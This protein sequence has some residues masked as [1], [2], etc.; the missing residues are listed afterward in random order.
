[1]LHVKLERDVDPI[2]LYITTD[3]EVLDGKIQEM[4]ICLGA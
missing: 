4:V 2:C 3:G 1:M